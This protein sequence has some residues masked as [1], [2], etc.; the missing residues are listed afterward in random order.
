MIKGFE[1]EREKEKAL[2]FLSVVGGVSPSSINLGD[3]GLLHIAGERKKEKSSFS[4]LWRI[5]LD[6][7]PTFMKAL[8]KFSHDMLWILSWG[9]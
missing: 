2:R 5:R 1:R 6:S 4:T 9:V 7:W 8:P 3:L